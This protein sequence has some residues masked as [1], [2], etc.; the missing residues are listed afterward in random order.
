MQEVWILSVTLLSVVGDNS[1]TCFVLVPFLYDSNDYPKDIVK[2]P[3]K[4]VLVLKCQNNEIH[5]SN[6][7]KIVVMLPI[8]HSPLLRRDSPVLWS[9][10]LRKQK[11]MC[12]AGSSYLERCLVLTRADASSLLLQGWQFWL[13]LGFGS[14]YKDLTVSLFTSICWIFTVRKRSGASGLLCPT[15]YFTVEM[16]DLALKPRVWV[17]VKAKAW[18]SWALKSSAFWEHKLRVT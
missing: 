10:R 5:T 18:E 8:K 3:P 16:G 11:S 17:R 4:K 7:R 2:G 12:S 6:S 14:E 9:F 13:S 15:L 1:W